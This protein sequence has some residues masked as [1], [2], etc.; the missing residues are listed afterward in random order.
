MKTILKLVALAAV[1]FVSFK[2]AHAWAA[3][4]MADHLSACTT[5][6]RLC[7]LVQQKASAAEVG[8]AMRQTFACVDGK[9]TWVESRLMPMRKPLSDPAAGA[10]DYAGAA[11]LCK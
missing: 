9:Q 11:A 3:I 6:E 10:M 4:R 7:R 5:K 2:A 8:A 1:L